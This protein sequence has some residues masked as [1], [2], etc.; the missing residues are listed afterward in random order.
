MSVEELCNRYLKTIQHRKP[1][2]IVAKTGVIKRIKTRWPEGKLQ[3]VGEVKTSDVQAFLSHESGR[4]GKS[5]YNQYLRTVREMEP[6]RSQRAQR[7]TG[8]RCV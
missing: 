1:S 2:T 7:S 5:S 4:M 8:N 3:Q 6:G